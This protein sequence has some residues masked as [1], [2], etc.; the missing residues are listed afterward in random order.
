MGRIARRA[1]IV[2]AAGAL[3]LSALTIG[4]PARAATNTAHVV[5]CGVVLPVATVSLGLWVVTPGPPVGAPVGAS[6]MGNCFTNQCAY[7]QGGLTIRINALKINPITLPPIIGVGGN[8]A[9]AGAPIK[10]VTPCP[11]PS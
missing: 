9:G 3:G 10:D 1:G 4:T 6:A 5:N 7:T 11:P 2:A 8:I